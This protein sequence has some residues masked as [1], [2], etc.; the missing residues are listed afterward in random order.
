MPSYIMHSGIALYQG[1]QCILD[2]QTTKFKGVLRTVEIHCIKVHSHLC[3]VE[4][5]HNRV[6]CV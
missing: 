3:M 5:N 1:K 2:D 4:V 6:Q